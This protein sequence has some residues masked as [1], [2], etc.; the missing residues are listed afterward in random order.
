M[1]R[2]QVLIR[3]MGLAGACVLGVT[4]GN[5]AAEKS[6]KASLLYQD[7]PHDGKRCCDC[8][9]FSGNSNSN[10]GICAIVEGVIDC[11]GWCTAFSPKA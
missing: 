9:F 2:R 4:T 10:T 6:S 8:K 7:R 11:N 3:G 1:K 5:A